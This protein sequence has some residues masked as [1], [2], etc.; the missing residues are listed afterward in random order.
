MSCHTRGMKDKADQVRATVLSNPDAYSVQDVELVKALYPPPEE[1]QALL[2]DDAQRFARA[3]EQT[4]GKVSDTDP[5]VVLAQRFESELD[6]TLA[7]AEFGVTTDE[8]LE[9]MTRSRELARLLGPLRI[10]GGTVKRDQLLRA[11]DRAVELL[12]VGKGSGEVPLVSSP[13]P[14]PPA[15]EVVVNEIGMMLQVIPA[16]QFQMGSPEA[17]E[18]RDDDEFQHAVRITRPFYLGAYEVTQREFQEVM[19]YNPSYF[20]PAGEG[21]GDLEGIADATGFPVEQVSWFDAIAFC[22]Q[23]S[24]RERLTP[25]Y[26]LTGI[27][28][29]VHGSIID[30]SVKILG[31]N[32]YRLPTEA[33]WEY[34]CRAGTST[35]FHFGT[36]LNGQEANVD[37]NYPY[38]VT[39]RGPFL[40]RTTTRGSYAPNAFGLFDM[41]GNV[42]EWCQDGYDEAFY[43]GSPVDDPTGVADPASGASRVLRGGS[44]VNLAKK[45]RAALRFESAPSNRFRDRGFR[46]A[47]TP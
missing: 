45:C 21:A 13:V 44:W 25:F 19:G 41:H 46:V 35:P 10:N 23:L 18:G 27:Q 3:V 47:R 6:L 17:E 8:L 24:Q 12:D 7:A 32:G 20:T 1:F 37:G 30:G 43:R 14:A 26:E 5:V 2:D 42:W 16:G 38:G 34:A 33:E 29:N 9:A 39:T 31:G 28:R 40:G 4:G 22:N 15:G 36:Q 11:F